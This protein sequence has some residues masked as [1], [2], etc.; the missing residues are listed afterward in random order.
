MKRNRQT[1][2]RGWAA[3]L[4]L[5]VALLLPQA[6]AAYDFMADGLCYNRNSDGTSVTVTYQNSSSPRYSN[7]SGDLVIPETVTYNGTTYS[8][9]SI[10]TNAFWNCSG[11]TS[12]TIP[13]SVTSIGNNPFYGCSGL[14]SMVV[15]AGNSTYDSRDNC[16]AIIETATNT[17]ISGCKTTTIPNSVTSIGTS[18]FRGCS[19]LT[20]VTI[21]NSVTSIGSGAFQECSG[22]TSVTIP[23]SVTAIGES[24]FAYC[25]GL[26]SVTI[27][28]SVTSIGSGA[29]Q[30]C[31]GLT[32][33]TIPNSVTSIGEY[34]F[35]YCS[36]LT[37][38]LVIPN[39]LTSIGS[40][41]FQECSGLTSVT[42]GNSVTTI[43]EY[44][45][46]NGEQRNLNRTLTLCGGIETIGDGAFG[47]YYGNTNV[48]T[49]IL[50]DEVVSI[51]NL[52]IKPSR[53]YSYATTPPECD[54]NT[55]KSYSGTLHVPASAMAA[56]F[57]APYWQN[58]TN[59]VG[60]A[61]E[62]TSL[63]LSAD[64][65]YVKLG[66]TL[67]L[68]AT[69]QPTD[70]TNVGMKW[71]SSEASI[72]TVNSSGVVTTL[73]P[74]ECD[75]TVTCADL[76][77]RC[78]VVVL[79]QQITITLDKHQLEMDPNTLQWL[80]PS[81]DPAA[82]DI[83]AV[84]S[85]TEVALIKVINNRVQVLAVKPGR[86]VVTVRSA[87]GKAVP[88]SCVVIV[89]GIQAESIALDQTEAEMTE[90]N[91]LQLTATILPD[92]AT[93]KTVSWH[94][95]DE[96]I[97]IVDASGLVTAVAPGTATITA[98]TQDGTSLS[99]SCQ[100]TVTKSVTPGDVNGDNKVNVSDYVTTASYILEQDPQPFI[101]AAADLD[102]NGSINVTDLV[103]VAAIA[104]TYPSEA[105]RHAPAMGIMDGD[106]AINATMSG[107]EIVVSLDNDVDITALQIDLTLPQGMSVAEA[108]LTDR[109]SA[110]H[111][112]DVAQVVNGNYR[113]LAASSALKAF[114]G[115]EGAV[116][117]I[118][119]SGEA[120]DVVTLHGIQLATPA[121][122][123][124]G[125]SDI[126]LAPLATGVHD[127]NAKTCIYAQDGNI[128]VETPVDGQVMIA[129]PNGMSVAHNVHAG[130]N[131]IAAPASGIVLVK[132]NG[133][134]A[135]IRL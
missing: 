63:T 117:R 101:F 20:S 131:V 71:H 66:S 106:V 88:D 127:A 48:A 132:M 31:S 124:I 60:D 113:L 12:V 39:S 130:R 81:F 7:L 94:S 115:H 93:I 86:A 112:V 126:L 35:A 135:K 64:T 9:T 119:L 42:V 70:A 27:G 102:E 13:N 90:G 108:T 85:N 84:N 32:S 40:G 74:G 49:L 80:T 83:V 53:I 61:V 129:L 37:G 105:P 59:I 43:G 95:D 14:E 79:E 56:Y 96:A 46:Y 52:G 44:A 116:L 133:S 5:A 72:A 125:H 123:G 97:A 4:L 121:A 8:V 26:T 22:L 45:F 29:F 30:E 3:A 55:F 36:G 78:H 103:G 118:S 67:N 68:Q 111:T 50:K 57:E 18:A 134:V 104:L 73:K 47:S 82:T 122:Q 98:T 58:F 23:N 51:K 54:D 76:M 110:S 16:N 89:K 24:A 1:L 11:L 128:V 114:K 15:A 109:A 62:P 65:A 10:R 91:V 17:L 25:S 87:D 77:A 33:V 21:P 41:A 34:A 107:N 19:G 6:A 99:A 28:N 69:L 75:I 38:E 92:N 120:Q 2:I 100:V